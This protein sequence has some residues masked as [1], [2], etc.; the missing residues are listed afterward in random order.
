M[1]RW[2]S[3]GPEWKTAD[4]FRIR[5]I[6]RDEHIPFKMPFYD[7]FFANTFNMP[8]EEKRWGILIRKKDMEK[9]IALLIREG[10]ACRALWEDS[11]E[12]SFRAAIPEQAPGILSPALSR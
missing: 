9:V 3:L 11:P 8:S 4:I 5:E 12:E 7:V 2:T 10:L 1:K 6:L